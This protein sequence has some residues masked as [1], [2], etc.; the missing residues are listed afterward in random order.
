MRHKIGYIQDVIK[1]TFEFPSFLAHN[2]LPPT[3]GDI[4]SIPARH[5]IGRQGST[6][7]AEMVFGMTS[8]FRAIK[9]IMTSGNMDWEMCG[10]CFGCAGSYVADLAFFC[11][12][13]PD[14]CNTSD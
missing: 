2:T 12:G 10:G 4:G 3:N 7:L 8:S 5:A 1:C 6:S 11:I 9:E 14:I 13:Q